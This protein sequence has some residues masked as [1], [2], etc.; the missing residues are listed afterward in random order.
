MITPPQNPK[1]AQAR[2]A[3]IDYRSNPAS[4]PVRLT[5]EQIAKLRAMYPTHFDSA[6]IEPGGQW[7]NEDGTSTHIDDPQYVTV[8]LF[9]KRAAE[10]E[11]QP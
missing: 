7:R 1:S 5:A 6:T 9:D 4:I 8:T 11:T 3:M 2:Q 10:R